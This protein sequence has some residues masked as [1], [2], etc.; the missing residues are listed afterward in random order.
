MKKIVCYFIC[1]IGFFSFKSF[2]QEP[3]KKY[4]FVNIKESV[5]KIGINSIIQDQYGF[6]WLSTNGS[7]LNRFDGI[8]YKTYQSKLKDS[9]SLSSNNVFC[10]YLDSKNRLWFGTDDG[11]DLYDRENDKF[12]RIYLSEF[13][14]NNANISVRSLKADNDGNLF[15]GTFELGLFKLNLDNFSVEKIKYED[16]S[17]YPTITIQAIEVDKKGNIYTSSD[18]G[19]HVV[20]KKTNTL[21]QA[22]FKTKQLSKSFKLKI[23]ELHIDNNDNLWL[24]T[25]IEGLYKIN[26]ISNSQNQFNEIVNYPISE[27][28]IMSIINL[29]DGSLLC[30]TEND[31]LI[32]INQN[33][34][35]INNYKADITDKD[36]IKSNS[37]WTLFLDN[38]QRIWLGY[39]NAGIGIYDKLYD[40]FNDLESLQNNPNSLQNGSVTAIVKDRFG[41]F[42]IA[43]DGGGID[44]FDFKTNNFTHINSNNE[45]YIS[46][47]TDDYIESLFIDSK[48]NVWAGS[49]NKG[50]FLLKKGTKKFIKHTIKSTNGGLKSNNILSFT[51]DSDGTIWF[52]S[53]DKGLHSYNPETEKFTHHDSKPFLENEIVDSYPRKIIIDKS[54]TLWMATTNKGVFKIK[55]QKDNTFSVVSMAQKMSEEFNNYAKANNILSIY[56][57]SNGLMW[58]GTR[59][60]GLCSYDSKLDKFT[61]YNSNNGLDAVNITGL[62]EDLEGYMW[63]TSNSGITKLDTETKTF[64][65]YSK[66]D[67]LL[68]NDFNVNA[69]FIDDDGTIFLGNYQG[70]DF[71]NPLNI[72]LNKTLP[73]LYLTGFK[74]F[75]KEVD[76]N[77][78]NAPLNSVVG[79]IS[80]LT[81]NHKQ[82]VFTIQYT[83]INYTRPEKNQ[84][85]YYLEGLEEDWNYVGNLRSATYTNLNQ[86]DY[87]FKLKAANSDGIWS[88]TPLSLKIKVLPPW[89]KTNEALF[90]YVA[91]ML[92]GIYFLN[93]MA[94]LRINK[95]QEETLE[96]NKRLQEKELNEKKFQFFTNISHEF[97]T[98]LTL[99]MNPISDIIRDE[100]LDF[101]AR[102]IDKHNIIHKNTQRLYRLINELLDFRKLESNKARISASKLNLFSFAK[103]IVSYFREEGHSNN[104]D[105]NLDADLADIPLWGDRNMLEKIIFNILSNALKVT[106]KGG[107][108]NIDL[109]SN[110]GLELLPLVDENN[111]VEV[112]KVVISDTG[113]GIEKEEVERIF[114]RFYQSKSLNKGYYGGTGIGLEVVRDF[115]TL[116]RGKI[117]VESEIGQGTTFTIILP[118][119]N[120]HFSEDEI[121]S[122]IVESRSN[123]ELFVPVR[124]KIKKEERVVESLHNYTLLIVEDN[125]ELRTYLKEEIGSEY[126]VLL[127]NNGKKG[128]ELAKEVL[129]DVIITD[130]IMPEMDGFDFCKKIK[131][132]IST[133]HIPLLMLTA[134]AKIDDRMD[135]IEVGADAYMIKPFDIRLLRLRVSQLITSRQ[136]IF[137]KYFSVISEV[138][139]GTRTSSLDK[140]FIEK[141]LDYINKNIDNPDLNVALLADKLNLSR[142]Q[143]YRKIKALTNQ[144]ANEF[145]RNIRLQK[146]K[147]ILEMGG[148]S[149]SEVCYKTGFSSPSYFSKCFK[150]YFQILPTEVVTKT[151]KNN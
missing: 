89:W 13:K 106:P 49:W 145:L 70:I 45:T 104:I 98:P 25:E 90:V 77:A 79:E 92:I 30:S 122:E 85:A 52:I 129:P 32:H 110:N 29:Q 11:L 130:V 82:S 139:E 118:V 44:L 26:K 97:R 61:W 47:L 42:W 105:I 146:A 86:G 41:K 136:L 14:K 65:K 55:K 94:Q 51:E 7:G 46:G 40:K 96:E 9:T 108:I 43:M 76:V 33:G 69:T 87:T 148:A 67:G 56:E 93:R 142:S 99:I 143:F 66:N 140:E 1:F 28:R 95:K 134:K 37:I 112:V 133:S 18:R 54:G 16:V 80:N 101:P 5:S 75:N 88:E 10:S 125:V 150:N 102:V 58:I 6:T 83:G 62:I 27:N 36:G 131:S 60:A 126:K 151:M 111:P 39:Y 127:A 68:S 128:L 71:F 115:I 107:A 19:L 38:N 3:V 59:G 138:P 109:K 117:E 2:S 50:L 120:S 121:A 91:L 73:S 48:E 21:K 124:T 149:I 8:D 17:K 35:V 15:I 132:D 34:V 141:V 23:K 64:T 31:G 4:T 78:K 81:L 100:T 114:E 113:S 53:W 119:G 57:G 123:D 103:E 135:G 84:Y 74:L 72:S 116:H 20:Y 12:K 144:T 147:Q 137:N 24:G 63:I 22:T